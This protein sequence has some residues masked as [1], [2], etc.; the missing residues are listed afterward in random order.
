MLDRQRLGE[1]VGRV[2]GEPHTLSP[3][4]LEHRLGSQRSVQVHVQLRLGP[5]PQQLLGEAGRAPPPPPHPP[6]EPAPLP[7]PPPSHHP[8][9][10]PP[11]GARPPPAGAPP[12]LAPQAHP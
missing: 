2:G 9:A 12:P 4:Q 1:P 5:A 8:A 10:P 7:P 6:H 11:R 3:R